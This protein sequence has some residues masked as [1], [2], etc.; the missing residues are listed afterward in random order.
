MQ[1]VFVSDLAEA[2]VRAL[3]VPEAVGEAFNIAHVEPLTQR[4]FVETLARVAGIVPTFAP[5]P[6]AAIQAAGGNPFAGN[7]YFGQYLDI[8]PHTSVIEKAPRVLGVRPTSL[9][10]AL[11]ESFAW[12][13]K[14]PRRQGD[15]TF[16]DRLLATIA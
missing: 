14:Q 4:S 7:L 6:R 11:G 3:E 8:P 16:E 12:Y 10:A 9:A 1:W 15:Y 13:Q 5:M 2:C